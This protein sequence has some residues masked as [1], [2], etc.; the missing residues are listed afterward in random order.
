MPISINEPKFV[1]STNTRS[2]EPTTRTGIANM[3]IAGAHTRSTVELY[4]MEK[5]SESGRRAADA[6]TGDSTT[7]TQNR[8]I[9]LNILNMID[10]GMFGL[11]L[12]NIF[13]IILWI[14][15]I[16]IIL[17]F[18]VLL[19]L[20]AYVPGVLYVAI[21]GV[22]LLLFLVYLLIFQYH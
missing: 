1:D 7:I 20:I 11:G 6:I 16:L 9:G 19:L 14:G 4:S 13:D 18:I 10:N 3:Y 17:L 2:Y 21:S 5:A 12:P 8:G 22:I 15:V